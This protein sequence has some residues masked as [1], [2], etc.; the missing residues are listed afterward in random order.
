MWNLVTVVHLEITCAVYDSFTS[1]FKGHNPTYAYVPLTTVAAA[2]AANAFTG[3]L[4]VTSQR[5]LSV[6]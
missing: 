5:F 3:G 4:R 2:E 6:S 1:L